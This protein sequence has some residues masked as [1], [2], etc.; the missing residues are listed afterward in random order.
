MKYWIVFFINVL[1]NVLLWIF[2]PAI[3]ATMHLTVFLFGL[4]VFD[5]EKRAKAYSEKLTNLKAV[6]VI[7]FKIKEKPQKVGRFSF[8]KFALKDI[9][10]K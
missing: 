1:G 9:C 7:E 5:V 10:K 2:C 4:F 8:L 3:V 6:P